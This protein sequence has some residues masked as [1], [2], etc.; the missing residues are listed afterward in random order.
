MV[1]AT[2]LKASA[3][4]NLVSGQRSFCH[5]QQQKR[6]SRPAPPYSIFKYRNLS[7]RATLSDA[8]C[9]HGF[10]LATQFHTLCEEPLLCSS[11]HSLVLLLDLL[12]RPKGLPYF[13]TALL[14]HRLFAIDRAADLLVL[15]PDPQFIDLQ[16]IPA[17]AVDMDKNRLP[18]I[19]AI[20][21]DI[22]L[23]VIFTFPFFG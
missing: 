2:P 19:K 8:F 7:Y 9:L 10:A 20:T 14:F 6:R 21:C 22:F 17:L 1:K 11:R 3:I 13:C 18:T 15:C 4:Q 16:I 23:N 12:Q 5:H